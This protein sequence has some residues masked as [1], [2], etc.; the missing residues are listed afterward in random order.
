MP[1]ATAEIRPL[2]S[3]RFLAAMMIVLHH[4]HVMEWPWAKM[5]SPVLN[6]GVSFF[7]VLS[8]FILTHVYSERPS[9]G[10]GGFLR[11]RY[12]RIWPVHVL[13]VVVLVA[14]VAPDSITFDGPGVFS[15]WVV[16][17][18]NLALLHA[19]VPIIAYT[20]SWNSVS[21][22]ISTEIFFYLAFPLL[23]R[24]IRAT[25]HYKLGG[26]LVMAAALLWLLATLNVPITSELNAVNA[27]AAT[28][29]SPIMR[30]FEFVL[31]MSVWVLWDRYLRGMQLSILM[32]TVLE[33]ICIGLTMMWLANVLPVL[34]SVNPW[35][36]LFLGP[37]GS[38]WVFSI[39][40]AL[41][42]SSQGVVALL[43]SVRPMV[44][45][46]GISFSVYM[47]HQIFFK[48]F[49]TTAAW[50][51]VPE[52]IYFA[53]LLGVSSLSYLLVE[54]PMQR[55]LSGRRSAVATPKE[56]VAADA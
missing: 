25:W 13:S 54:R 2:T 12:A 41:F 27:I 35:V 18:A 11:A 22:S 15:K 23:L 40:I 45:L 48:Y 24:N 47:L 1:V 55:V 36:L 10:L 31:G 26:A 38:C 8:G 20:F 16:L 42:A 32:W 52:W 39:L 17:V 30:G 5:L 34:A 14:I 46:G 33:L 37:V 28:Y 21:W 4:A 56:S 51:D 50:P 7:F 29:P 44:F 19:I 49:L 53:V 3:L 9:V 43:L 6:H